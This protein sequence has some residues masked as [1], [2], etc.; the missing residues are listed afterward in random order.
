MLSSMCSKKT[1]Q[2]AQGSSLEIGKM[3]ETGETLDGSRQRIHIV[4]SLTLWNL[5]T[6]N[7]GVSPVG[8]FFIEIYLH[9]CLCKQYFCRPLTHP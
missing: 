2:V 3:E 8:L 4:H 9:K 7:S 6:G 1:E 5:N